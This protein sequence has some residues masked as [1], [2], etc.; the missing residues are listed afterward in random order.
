VR[1]PIQL[2]FRG[3]FFL[4][5]RLVFRLQKAGIFYGAKLEKVSGL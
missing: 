2:H 3:R 1:R 4:R 5:R